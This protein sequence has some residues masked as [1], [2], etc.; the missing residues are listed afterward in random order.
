MDTF[1]CDQSACAGNSDTLQQCA[2][3]LCLHYG[4]GHHQHIYS[5]VNTIKAG[6]THRSRMVTVFSIEAGWK[7]DSDKDK[8]RAERHW[9]PK[10]DRPAAE[11]LIDWNRWGQSE[12]KWRCFSFRQW[13]YVADRHVSPAHLTALVSHREGGHCTEMAMVCLTDFEEYAK[14]HLSKATWDYYAAGADEC[15]TRDDNLLAYKR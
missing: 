10:A 11:L 5:D 4:G 12:L 9:K 8:G 6:V 14:E 3:R 2:R 15:C 7:F 1:T 13:V